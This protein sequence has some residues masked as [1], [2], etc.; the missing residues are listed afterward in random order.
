MLALVRRLLRKLHASDR[1]LRIFFLL[2]SDT[3]AQS[4]D[5]WQAED[6]FILKPP[7]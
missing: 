2:S 3:P 7:L 1:A 4:K 6:D 5:L